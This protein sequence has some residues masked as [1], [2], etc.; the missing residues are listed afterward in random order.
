MNEI[1][2]GHILSNVIYKR[3]LDII[4]EEPIRKLILDRFHD[5]FDYVWLT[6]YGDVVVS[7]E[8]EGEA[9][10]ILQEGIF[11][12]RKYIKD[13]NSSFISLNEYLNKEFFDLSIIT[14]LYII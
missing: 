6:L 14:D 9:I 10:F 12:Y 2:L 4:N 7:V 11:R 5:K 8:I 13:N 1:M 3:L